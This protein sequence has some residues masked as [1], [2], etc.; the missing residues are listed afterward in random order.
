MLT[1]PR[2]ENASEKANNSFSRM[3]VSPPRWA[4]RCPS[5]KYQPRTVSSRMQTPMSPAWSVGI[6]C[7]KGTSS[8]GMPISIMR[9]T[10]RM[11]TSCVSS[12]RSVTCWCMC[13]TMLCRPLCSA[14]SKA[15]SR[16]PPSGVQPLRMLPG[17]CRSRSDE[18]P[19]R[20]RTSWRATVS[21]GVAAI[22]MTSTSKAGNANGQ[23]SSSGRCS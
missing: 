15:S 4:S 13:K 14:T 16:K 21:I 19:W 11:M 3:A 10:A 18:K 22:T 2:T 1:S 23:T 17:D 6:H 7:R 12:A 9:L 20:K 5:V 8:F